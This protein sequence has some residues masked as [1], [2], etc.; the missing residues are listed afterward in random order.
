MADAIITADALRRHWVHSHE[1]DTDTAM[2]LRPAEYRFP[3]SRGRVGYALNAGGKLTEIGPGPTDRP[4]ATKGSW[5]LEGDTLVLH[6]RGSDQRH[7][8]V[9][10]EPERLVIAR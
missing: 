8:I 9:S 5:A 10:F 1:E 7:R 4:E 6:L 2:V 3:P